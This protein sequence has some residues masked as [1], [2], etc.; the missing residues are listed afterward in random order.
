MFPLLDMFFK[1]NKKKSE[2]QG[3]KKVEIIR[4]EINKDVPSND[5]T[6]G[7]IGVLMIDKKIFCYTLEPPYRKNTT[8]DSAIPIGTYICG[9]YSS[10]KYSSTFEIMNVTGRSF[11][12][13]HTGNTDADTLG[14]IILGETV[15]YLGK[16][17]AVLSSRKI[18]KKFMN[19][20]K[21]QKEF[22][23]TI[24]EVY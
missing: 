18:F 14:C 24:K 3:M 4:L 5:Q 17:R 2:V 6:K 19:I 15:G 12:L 16:K 10:Q 1:Q 21:N 11:I 8:K 7:I 23:L 20:M 22:K 13:F 9:V